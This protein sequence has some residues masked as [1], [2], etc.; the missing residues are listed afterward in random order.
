[1]DY[2]FLVRMTI[3]TVYS[4]FGVL[5]ISTAYG[6]KTRIK[7]GL[8]TLLIAAWCLSFDLL[9]VS[10]TLLSVQIWSKTLFIIA[11]L[12]ILLFYFLSVDFLPSIN[13]R[14]ITLNAVYFIVFII[15]ASQILFTE[16]LLTGFNPQGRTLVEKVRPNKWFLLCLAFYFYLSAG[17]FLN[18][19]KAY[20]SSN[21]RN[22]QR[23][24]YLA[25]STCVCLV[26]AIITAGVLPVFGI[27]RYIWIGPYT[28]FIIMAMIYAVY[29]YR[30]IELDILA[31]KIAIGSLFAVVIGALN[32]GAV[33]L[34]VR[35]L[36]NQIIFAHY[37]IVVLTNVAI[38]LLLIADVPRFEKAARELFISE[39]EEYY[40]NLEHA[41]KRCAAFINHSGLLDYIAKL[42]EEKMQISRV[43]FYLQ[44]KNRDSNYFCI[45]RKGADA[46]GCSTVI[47]REHALIAHLKKNQEVLETGEFRH[48][49]GHLFRNGQIID[50]EKHEIQAILDKELLAA[51]VIPLVR[52]DVVSGMIVL[53]EKKAGFAY[54]SYDLQLLEKL[55]FNLSLTLENLELKNRLIEKEKMALIGT[56]AASLAHEIHNPLTSVKSLVDMLPR[57][58]G[59][60]DYLE[61]FMSLVPKDIER[62]M[63]ITKGLETFALPVPSI[64]KALNLRLI[65]EQALSLLQS[66][67]HTSHVEIITEIE[68]LPEI[69]ADAKKITQLFVNIILNAIQASKA[70]QRIL[71]EAK[72]DEPLRIVVNVVDQGE[73]IKPEAMDKIFK[74]FYSTRIYG[75]GLGLPTCKMI[76]EELKGEIKVDSS[77]G[78]GTNITVILPVGR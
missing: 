7:V 15:I 31:R 52:N 73:G 78:K 11:P 17:Y 16:N 41:L 63:A 44:D 45:M 43:L 2:A 49:Y 27:E 74:P 64:P 48:K 18:L 39:K 62:V 19:M 14:A 55:A 72:A 9:R 56:I 68:E 37:A 67:I 57:K 28:S 25:V 21:Q 54:N 29:K 5:A 76:V 6:D 22:Q 3:I 38:A 23:I 77:E 75:T 32:A 59:S 10:E 24:L 53:G 69:E 65:I 42:L 51:I 58:I 36:G 46:E 1:M 30:V 71:I 40:K 50:V 4:I 12:I 61:T 66:Q 35:I 33:Y 70:G 26:I 34:S 8:L 13:R 20:Q 60:K 47:S